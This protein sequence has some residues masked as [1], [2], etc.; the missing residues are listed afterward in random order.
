MQG[1][2]IL[3]FVVGG[4]AGYAFNGIVT[5]ITQ[6]RE[7]IDVNGMLDT[8]MSDFN[9]VCDELE[10]HGYKLYRL[11][12]KLEIRKKKKKVTKK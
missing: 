2:L 11:N 8:V 3:I 9:D 12:G 5:H 4:I 6:Y 7:H 10:Q 1:Q